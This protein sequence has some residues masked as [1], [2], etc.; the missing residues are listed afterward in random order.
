MSTPLVTNAF[1]HNFLI[2]A[3]CTA[4]QWR[5]EVTVFRDRADKSRTP[6]RIVH[7]N[8][9][10]IPVASWEWV[11]FFDANGTMVDVGE[12]VAKLAGGVL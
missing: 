7:G 1:T 9:R 3:E 5:S 2:T 10:D 11:A 6:Y 4:Q 8:V 12:R